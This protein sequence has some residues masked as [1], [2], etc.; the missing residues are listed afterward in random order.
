[1]KKKM[2]AVLMIA[3][4]SVSL[5]VACGESDNNNSEQTNSN[6]NENVVGEL[7]AEGGSVYETPDSENSNKDITDKGYPVIATYSSSQYKETG[8]PTTDD[9]YRSIGD[10]ITDEYV[11][12][13]VVADCG[14]YE[15]PVVIFNDL[16]QVKYAC[17]MITLDG[18]QEPTTLFSKI[19][20]DSYYEESL[21][22]GA[23][24]TVIN[25]VDIKT[26]TEYTIEF[27]ETASG[28]IGQFLVNDSV[29]GEGGIVLGASDG[30]SL[31]Q[32]LLMN[33]LE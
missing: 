6:T 33:Y 2:Y 9:V 14:G 16:N 31:I 22:D 26:G 10:F 30:S 4:M 27:V 3:I 8:I 23:S 20:A 32:N 13:T 12:K 11:E 29:L 21:D 17:T 25:M 7:P 5:L 15:S 24:K 1:M 18:S 19:N 28:E